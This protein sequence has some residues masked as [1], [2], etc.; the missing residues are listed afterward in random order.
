MSEA[1]VLHIGAEPQ[2]TPLT[3]ESWGKLGMVPKYRARR[4]AECH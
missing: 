4:F 2:E 1:A 3:P